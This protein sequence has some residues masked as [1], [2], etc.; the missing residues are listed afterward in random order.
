MLNLSLHNTLNTNYISSI[1]SGTQD[2]KFDPIKHTFFD[3]K[4]VGRPSHEC[5]V[6]VNRLNL[7]EHACS[8]F[9][10][11]AKDFVVEMRFLCGLVQ[12]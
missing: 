10:F 2:A 9:S 6:S 8:F 12:R 7:K 11:N 4:P 3:Y 5:N 1:P